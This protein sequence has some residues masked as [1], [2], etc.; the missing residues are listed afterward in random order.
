MREQQSNTDW[1]VVSGTDIDRRSVNRAVND[2]SVIRGGG[3]RGHVGYLVTG[4]GDINTLNLVTDL[5]RDLRLNSTWCQT[6]S[7]TVTRLL[8]TTPVYRVFLSFP[9]H[10]S[11]P[12]LTLAHGD[13]L[14][15]PSHAS[16]AW[17][18]VSPRTGYHFIPSPINLTGAETCT[19]GDP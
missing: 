11:K 10:V 15:R 19:F 2:V 5:T 8:S 14:G 1:S 12:Q 18:M 7:V 16:S 17:E 9:G 6:I 4:S 13:W 3:G